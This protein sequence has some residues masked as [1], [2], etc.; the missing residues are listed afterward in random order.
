MPDETKLKKKLDDIKVLFDA[1]RNLGIC[2]TLVL[3]LKFLQA[4]M[5]TLGFTPLAQ[6][7]SNW[8]VILLVGLLVYWN[9]IWMAL[10]FKTKPTSLVLH[11]VGLVFVISLG[12]TVTATGLYTLLQNVPFVP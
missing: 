7:M 8:F 6:A 5:I 10:S 12:L 3:S 2:V 11:R 9:V 1:L 4:P